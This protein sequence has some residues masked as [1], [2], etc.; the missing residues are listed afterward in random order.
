MIEC[1]QMAR[2]GQALSSPTRSALL[3]ILMDGR[4]F[5]NKELA[6]HAGI[7]PQ[8]TTAHLQH[9]EALGLTAS[10]KSGRCIYHRIATQEVAEYLEATSVLP[11]AGAPRVQAPAHLRAARCCYAHL[12]GRLGVAVAQSLRADG[13]VIG[14]ETWCLSQKGEAWAQSLGLKP[15][16][17]KPC[18]D[19]TER[20]MH[21]A[22]P[23]AVALMDHLL[24][25]G[26]LA[27]SASKRGLNVL[28][29][30]RIRDMGVH[31]HG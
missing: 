25:E 5:T 29:P 18:L 13:R 12:A 10:V 6:S 26:I 14:T 8:T 23:F 31:D 19:W 11:S 16:P 21:L 27:H 7:S 3:C 4:A 20:R 2:I 15:A 1:N 17:L 22:G 28:A 9:L 24:S 30:D